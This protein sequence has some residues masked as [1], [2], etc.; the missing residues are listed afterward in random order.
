[1]IRLG[2]ALTIAGVVAVLA[3]LAWATANPAEDRPRIVAVSRLHADR[4]LRPLEARAR[5]I[6][7]PA[8]EA[9]LR[10]AGYRVI[11]AR[12]TDSVWIA[13]RDSAGGF[14]DPI[15]GRVIDQKLD[16]I[17]KG[18]R[19]ALASQFAAHAWLHVNL[20]SVAPGFSGDHAEW[21]GTSEGTGGRGGMAGFLIGRSAGTLNALSL[22]L[23]A[24]DTRD[25]SRLERRSGGI[26]LSSKII[27]GTLTDIPLDQLLRDE[28]R[29]AAAVLIAVDS[30]AVHWPP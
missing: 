13:H 6:F 11:P 8:I 12:V 27:E 7:G 4:E 3:V 2:A 1:M 18:T 29:N 21:H 22:R 9:R 30:L 26:Q 14:Y 5:E 17:W 23:E 24:E 28:A 19:Q 16:L 10:E 20:I 15:T 25:G